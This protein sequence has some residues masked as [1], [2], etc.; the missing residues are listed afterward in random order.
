MANLSAALQAALSSSSGSDAGTQ[1]LIALASTV[2]QQMTQTT[3]LAQQIQ[4][5]EMQR[6]TPLRN[7]A[8]ILVDTKTLGRVQRF[9]GQK[10]DWTD[11]SFSFRAYLGGVNSLAVE[12]LD[13]AAVQMDPITDGAIDLEINSELVHELNKQIY[14]ALCLLVQGDCLD[15]LRQVRHGAGL[16]AW[17][18][19]S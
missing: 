10:K 7:G 17:R 6:V 3:A 16:E 1:L 5:L 2:Q 14:T 19:T 18:R 13:W 12:A 11:W 15:K 8:N 4:Q 9:K